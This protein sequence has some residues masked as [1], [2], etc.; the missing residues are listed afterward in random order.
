LLILKGKESDVDHTSRITEGGADGLVVGSTRVVVVVLG[1]RMTPARSLARESA[2][3]AYPEA[4][5]PLEALPAV[6]L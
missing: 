5:A 2:P 3:F 4:L 6:Q 1:T